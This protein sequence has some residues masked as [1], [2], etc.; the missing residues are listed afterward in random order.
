MRNTSCASGEGSSTEYL[1]RDTWNTRKGTEDFST[2][3][4]R[5]YHQCIFRT[6]KNLVSIGRLTTFRKCF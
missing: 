3:R 5:Q 4:K 2:G 6:V 1:A